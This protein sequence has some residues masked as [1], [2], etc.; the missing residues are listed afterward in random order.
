MNT[1][2]VRYTRYS[3]PDEGTDSSLN[4]GAGE[5]CALHDKE[6]GGGEEGLVIGSLCGIMADWRE[7]A[8][9]AVGPQSGVTRARRHLGGSARVLP[10]GPVPFMTRSSRW[11]RSTVA[12]YARCLR[13]L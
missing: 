1:V 8:P 12:C 3:V 6:G 5:R 10:A 2:Q 11:S 4:D 9:G 7:A 13:R